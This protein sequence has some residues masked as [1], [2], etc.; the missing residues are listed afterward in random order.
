MWRRLGQTSRNSER[1]PD[2][3]YVELVDMVVRPVFPVVFMGVALACVGLLLASRKQDIALLVLALA[4]LVVNVASVLMILAYRRRT[5]SATILADEARVWERRFA[6]G[7]YSFAA[8]LGAI[9]GRGLFSQHPVDSALVPMLTSGMAFVFAGGVL[10][11]VAFRPRLCGIAIALSATPTI[12]GCLD[13]ATQA[14][15]IH[16]AAGFTLQALLLTGFALAGL[17]WAS[18]T[19]EG[20]VRQIVSKLDFAIMARR[21]DLTG[22]ANRVALRDQFEAAVAGLIGE[23]GLLAIL[24]L[25]LD[26]FKAV[27]DAY[28]HSTGDAL[29]RAAASRLA[30]AVRRE[31]TAARLGGDEFVVLQ[32]ELRRPDEALVLAHRIIRSLSAPYEIEGRR[33]QIGVSIGVAIAPR[34]GWALDDLTA[35]ADAAL[36][37]MKRGGR[38]GVAF[39]GEDLPP[40]PAANAG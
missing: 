6:I 9:N 37:S 30:S 28:G 40:A 12:V 34:D 36:Y 18:V 19:Y 22:L 11:N 17:G 39:W 2:A 38:G 7:L 20:A 24:C 26:R 16:V 10:S 23:G 31:D 14:T 4:A 35:R 33:I 3:A 32:T 8:L 13:R 5:A 25:D 21:D 1:L 15:D 27:N 29:L